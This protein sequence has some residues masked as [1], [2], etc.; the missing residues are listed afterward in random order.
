[1]GTDAIPGL[2]R[3][4]EFIGGIWDHAASA[5][6]DFADAA[7]NETR[8]VAERV[9]QTADRAVDVLAEE[10]HQAI[11]RV[12][13]WP[14]RSE[15]GLETPSREIEQLNSDGDRVM[16]SLTQE[17]K[18]QT[19]AG[20]KEQYGYSIVVEQVGDDPAAGN[21]GAA[22]S[23]DVTFD[24]NLL[25]GLYAEIPTIAPTELAGVLAGP[26]NASLV[27]SLTDLEPVSEL[28]LLSAD[29]V[30]MSFANEAEAQQ[31]IGILQRVAANQAWRNAQLAGDL[32]TNPLADQ[33]LDTGGSGATQITRSDAAFLQEHITSYSTTLTAQNRNKVKNEFNPLVSLGIEPRLDTN[34][35]IVRTVELPSNGE[36]GRLT[37]TV[38]GDLTPSTKAK[39]GLPLDP[40]PDDILKAEL[41][42][43]IIFDHGQ[44]SAE[45]SVS[46]NLRDSAFDNTAGSR[47]V[48]EASLLDDLSLGEPD[49]VSARLQLDY[50]KPDLE[51]SRTNMGRLVVDAS[52]T[53][54]GRDAIDAVNALLNGDA[55]PAF[56]I[57]GDSLAVTA[58]H[59]DIERHGFHVQPEI[60][61]EAF[62]LLEAKV[63]LIANL[64]RDDVQNRR[65]I[66]LGG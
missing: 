5:P 43:Q 2:G 13:N 19:G 55:G 27:A 3:A 25:A 9:G 57:A 41:A 32:V 28:N 38:S 53:L 65:D 56:N 10:F 48:P 7:R 16:L 24:K 40:L 47:I 15:I 17:G 39:L 63:S 36:P 49:A 35:Q 22:P 60:G 4:R 62:K 42:P 14:E 45:V 37:Y 8:P 52:T 44:V 46:W 50:Q 58:R 20:L 54:P 1:M 26:Q 66:T 21:G 6:S 34:A 59:E 51:L 11:E 29:S 33:L 18:L 64:G 23:Y 12:K 61:A 30:T 31:A